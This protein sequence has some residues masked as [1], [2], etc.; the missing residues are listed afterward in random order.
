[1][2]N[3]QTVLSKLDGQLSYAEGHSIAIHQGL[4]LAYSTGSGLARVNPNVTMTSL[5]RMDVLSMSKTITAAGVVRQLLVKGLTSQ[6]KIGGHLP[7]YW[8]VN[9]TVANLTFAH[10]LT[11]SG[12][13]STNTNL[14]SGPALEFLGVEQLCFEPP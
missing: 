5:M 14:D 2:A 3:L 1:M 9:P 13:L 12:G 4:N 8:N 10:V 6:E 11:H 7:A